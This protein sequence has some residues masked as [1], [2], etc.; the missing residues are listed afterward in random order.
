MRNWATGPWHPHRS[1]PAAEGSI[2]PFWSWR[3]PLRSAHFCGTPSEKARAR[4]EVNTTTQGPWLLSRN[5]W[6]GL[7][8]HPLT[9]GEYPSVPA[10]NCLRPIGSLWNMRLSSSGAD[11]STNY[12]GLEAASLKTQEL[13][14]GSRE[15]GAAAPGLRFAPVRFARPGAPLPAGITAPAGFHLHSLGTTTP[16]DGTTLRGHRVVCSHLSHAHFPS[17]T[18]FL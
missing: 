13:V 15:A 1:D 3:Q 5:R 4:L 8:D 12:S 11:V 2:L 6:A 14:G 9:G 16:Q 17:A 18:Q 10:R 7:W